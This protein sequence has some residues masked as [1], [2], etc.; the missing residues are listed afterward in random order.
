[1]QVSSTSAQEGTSTLPITL[2]E[3]QQEAI[4]AQPE[5]VQSAATPPARFSFWVGVAFTLNYVIGSGFLTIPWAFQQTGPAIGVIVLFT[6]GIFSVL[7]VMFLLETTDRA[8]RLFL[9]GKEVELRRTSRGRR[10]YLSVRDRSDEFSSD[11]DED[12]NGADEGGEEYGN[13]NAGEKDGADEETKPVSSSSYNNINSSSKRSNNKSSNLG[14]SNS[15]VL[16]EKKDPTASGEGIHEPISSD[17]DKDND[18]EAKYMST[19]QLMSQRRSSSIGRE[20]KRL[21]AGANRASFVDGGVFHDVGLMIF[22]NRRFEIVELCEMFLGQRGKQIFSLCII[23]YIYG[24][25]W[26]YCTVFARAFAA[27]VNIGEQSYYLYLLMFALIVVPMSLMELTEQVFVQVTLAILRILMVLIMV[28]TTIIAAVTDGE[29]FG[30]MPEIGN[31]PAENALRFHLGKIYVLLP[32]AAYAYIFHH[33]V[34]ALSE[35]VRDRNSLGR[36]FSTALFIAF[37]GYSLLGICVCVYFGAN[38][39]QSSNLNWQTF[40]GLQPHGETPFYAWVISFFVVLFPAADVA[41]AYPLNAFTLGNTLM[42][43]YY[44]KDILKYEK[45]VTQARIFRL[46]AAL[47]PFFG[48]LLVSDLSKITGYTGLTGFLLAFVFPPL[49]AR[50]SA[51]KMVSL[52]MPAPTKFSSFWTQPLF[53]NILCSSGVLLIISVTICSIFL[54]DPPTRDA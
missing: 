29:D 24:T 49:L 9:A 23:V 11:E 6:F 10:T 19:F 27:N 18:S 13:A 44:G 54:P 46:L 30:S 39:Q 2:M 32:I 5:H 4:D 20:L 35:P 26:A 53:Q 38:T 51:D 47:P 21:E 40:K 8:K 34:P 28:S 1:M 25:L 48:A 36:I 14:S 15:S 3:S 33:S 17:L 50:F 16:F 7:A 12:C 31:D 22:A 41:S 37:S 52:G 45:S 42:S 43:T